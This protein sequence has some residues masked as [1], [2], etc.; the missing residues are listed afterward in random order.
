MG[1]PP[2]SGWMRHNSPT[3]NSGPRPS[4]VSPT[5][6]V[7]VPMAGTL[8]APSSAA[9][10][11]VSNVSPT[12]MGRSVATAHH[13][14]QLFRDARESRLQPGVH[15]SA[16]CLDQSPAAGA[17]LNPYPLDARSAMQMGGQ[18]GGHRVDGL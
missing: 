13:F 18:V 1:L 7:T 10:T 2:P 11:R 17:L 14:R 4:M 3:V 8:A 12:G 5:R 6:R 9:L 16:L 15:L